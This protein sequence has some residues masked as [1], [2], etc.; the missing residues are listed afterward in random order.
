[1]NIFFLNVDVLNSKF[2][3]VIFQL[4]KIKMLIGIKNQ[5]SNHESPCTNRTRNEIQTSG[6]FKYYV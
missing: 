2:D 5:I 1:M 6:R 3:R 4:S